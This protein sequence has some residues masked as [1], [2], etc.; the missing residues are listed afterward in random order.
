MVGL[1]LTGDGSVRNDPPG[2]EIARLASNGPSM[3]LLATAGFIRRRSLARSFMTGRAFMN[4]QT[5]R[6]FMTRQ[7]FMTDRTG[8]TFFLES[9]FISRPIF[10]TRYKEKT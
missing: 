6:A 10:K 1:S 4:V 2:D 3:G 9:I 7:T 5:G 8:Q